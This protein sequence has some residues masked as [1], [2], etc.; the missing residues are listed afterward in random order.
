MEVKKCSTSFT[1]KTRSPKTNGCPIDKLPLKY[2]EEILEKLRVSKKIYI[3]IFSE[4]KKT[5]SEDEANK[6]RAAN[7]EIRKQREEIAE[8]IAT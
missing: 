7:E 5:M 8:K 3:N 4:V 1:K 2:M 6:V